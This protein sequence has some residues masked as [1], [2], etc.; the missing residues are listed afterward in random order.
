M[1]EAQQ[2]LYFLRQLKK[3]GVGQ[4]VL[5]HFY[6]AVIESVLT[7]SITVWYG[8]ASQRDK[9]SLDRIVKIAVKII[10]CELPSIESLYSVR[11]VRK[12]KKKSSLMVPTRPITFSSFFPP[13]NVLDS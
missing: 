5:I 11:L 7:F 8:N 12:S 13:R 1:N 10:G 4:R 6:R 9:E 3:F 2:R